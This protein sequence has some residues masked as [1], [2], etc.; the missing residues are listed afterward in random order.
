MNPS[1]ERL[2]LD[3]IS[4]RRRGVLAG[5]A[6]AVLAIAEPFYAAATAL[7]N[8]AYNRGIFPVRRLSKPTISVGNLTTGGTGKTPMVCWLAK[9]LR[10][11]DFNPAV[12]MRGYKSGDGMSDE[13]RLIAESVGKI[14]VIADADRVRGAQS[15][16]PEI[17]LFIL[18]DGMQHRRVGRD[19]DLVLV[20][21]T[22]PWGFGRLLPRGLLR[23]SL[24]GLARADAVIVTH[25]N[26]V[27]AEELASI[28]AVIRRHGDAP[29]FHANHAHDGF[30]TDSGDLPM[31]ALTDRPYF[32]A[33][34]IAQ[35]EGFAAAL[36]NYGKRCVGQHFFPDHHFFTENETAQ[37]ISQAATGG[38][39]AIV[40]TEKDWTKLSQL[41]AIKESK[42]PFWRVQLNMQFWNEDEK[43]LLELVLR[44]I[45]ISG[46]Q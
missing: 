45:R 17:D 26:E 9:V 4:G 18:D 11:N 30:F 13:G 28:D 29:I 10:E 19:V 43:R 6:R 24:D 33:C 31:E 2:Y 7:R 41:S 37:L 1:G 34:G 15:A 39:S 20:N 44:A 3:V 22:D 32:A 12:L 38:A 23:E 14:T 16:E 40:V 42:I 46:E 36:L 8:L 35:P 27:R 5:A 21:A 25:A